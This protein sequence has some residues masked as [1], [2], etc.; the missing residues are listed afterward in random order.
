MFELRPHVLQRS[1]LVAAIDELAVE[2]PWSEPTVE[3]EV[4]RQTDTQEAVAY[5]TSAS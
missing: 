2:G 4:P 1:G 3:I 5:R